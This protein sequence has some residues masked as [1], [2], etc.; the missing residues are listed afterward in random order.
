M[1]WGEALHLNDPWNSIDPAA[2]S[3]FMGIL[4]TTNRG[5]PIRTHG[6]FGQYLQ[7][8]GIY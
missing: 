4:T 8:M 2:P 5:F 7:G 6:T 1:S 3:G